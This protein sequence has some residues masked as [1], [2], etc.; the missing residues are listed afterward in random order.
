[1]ALVCKLVIG[2]LALPMFAIAADVP[3]LDAVVEREHAAAGR[4]AM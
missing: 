3:R 1:V 4:R 2:L